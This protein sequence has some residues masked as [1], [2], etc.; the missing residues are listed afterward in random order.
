M[1]GGGGGGGGLATGLR[2]TLKPIQILC[3]FFL[4]VFF[5]C[6][7]VFVRFEGGSKFLI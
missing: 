6:V 4:F 1:A 7:V 5:A 2:A 3:F